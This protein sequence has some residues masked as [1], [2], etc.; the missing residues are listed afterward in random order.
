MP[1]TAPLTPPST[2]SLEGMPESQT[3]TMISKHDKGLLPAWAHH[4]NKVK[5]R[6]LSYV[7]CRHISKCPRLTGDRKDRHTIL[8]RA[9]S[10]ALQQI[11]DLCFD[12]DA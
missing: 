6:A 2:S 4:C 7:D 9:A 8:R 11:A 1:P 5:A 3:Y 12:E 10:C